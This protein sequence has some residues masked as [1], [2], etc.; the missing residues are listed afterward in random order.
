MRT[1]CRQVPLAPPKEVAEAEL[2][3]C[4]CW[5]WKGLA[6]DEGEDAAA[7]LTAVLGKPCRLVRYVG[8]F[9]TS[10][11][12]TPSPGLGRW[13]VDCTTFDGRA[14][15]TTTVGTSWEACTSP[16]CD[17]CSWPITAFQHWHDVSPATG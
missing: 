8:A 10:R 4:T 17:M 3:E 9:P 2:K 13:H 6:R 15:H 1:F 16:A 5:D 7:W 12:L 11:F 14:L